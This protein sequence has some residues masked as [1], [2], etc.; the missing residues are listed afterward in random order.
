MEGDRQRKEAESLLKTPYQVP[1]TNLTIE[2]D[3]YPTLTDGKGGIHKLRSHFLKF[4]T[5]LCSHF[6]KKRVTAKS[7]ILKVNPFLYFMYI[8]QLMILI[9]TVI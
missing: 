8:F 2:M 5:P 7:K 4:L 1:G 3:G 6:Y 9:K